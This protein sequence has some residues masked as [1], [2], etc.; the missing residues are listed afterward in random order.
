MR[1]RLCKVCRGWHRL[2]EWPDECVTAARSLRADLALPGIVT[3]GMKPL[4]SQV[5]GRI[6]DK[7]SDLMAHYK[8]SGVRIVDPG[9]KPPA[10]EK[11]TRKEVRDMLKAAGLN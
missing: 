6:Y 7:R 8:A 11:T 1:E 4:Q 2:D 10:P 3:D 5:D 9:E